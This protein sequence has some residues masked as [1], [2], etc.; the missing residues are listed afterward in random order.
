MKKKTSIFLI[1]LLLS[2]SLS[3]SKLKPAQIKVF[4]TNGNEMITKLVDFSSRTKKFEFKNDKKVHFSKIWMINF[5]NTDWYFPKDIGKRVKNYDLIVLKN[6]SYIVDKIIDFS[7]R[8]RVFEFKDHKPIHFSK[9]KR[10]YFRNSKKPKNLI[11]HSKPTAIK[12]K[13]YKKIIKSL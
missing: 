6:G 12:P 8:R 11:K 7:S 2:F 4:L 10:I 9:I 1:I 5:V 3:A 13:I